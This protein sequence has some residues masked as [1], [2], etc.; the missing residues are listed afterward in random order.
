MPGLYNTADTIIFP[1]ANLTGKFD[2]PLII[3]EAYACGK[4]VIL[5]DLPQFSEFANPD[6]CVTIPTDSG[7]KLIESLAYLKDNQA[8]RNRLG[9]NARRFVKDHFDL[10]NTAKQYEEIYTSL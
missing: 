6:I 10:K 8:E 4:P 1:V 7:E 3:I 5:S 9:E 2:V